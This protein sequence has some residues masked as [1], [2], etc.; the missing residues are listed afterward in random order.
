MSGSKNIRQVHREK[1]K[2]MKTNVII[3][4]SHQISIQSKGTLAI[5]G[6]SPY[7]LTLMATNLML[8]GFPNLSKFAKNVIETHLD[9][10]GDCL[11]FEYNLRGELR[12]PQ[13]LMRSVRNKLMREINR[14]HSEAL[15]YDHEMYNVPDRV[16]HLV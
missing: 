9:G 10:L 14:A 5:I 4:Q 2:K 13:K 1:V 11:I 12:N 15:K 16:E 6:K 7:A 3:P 8:V